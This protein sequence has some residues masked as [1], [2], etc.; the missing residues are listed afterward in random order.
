MTKFSKKI[1]YRCKVFECTHI[2]YLTMAQRAPITPATSSA[3]QRWQIIDEATNSNTRA[4]AMISK[5]CCVHAIDSPSYI[6]KLV[7]GSTWNLAWFRVREIAWN[8]FTWRVPFHVI[9]WISRIDVNHF[10]WNSGGTYVEDAGDV[11]HTYLVY[12]LAKLIAKWST[13][14][15]FPCTNTTNLRLAQLT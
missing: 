14:N 4:L 13:M 15:H 9:T 1:V 3:V 8:C 10:T 12:H 5:A 11:V 6:K 2:A 7:V